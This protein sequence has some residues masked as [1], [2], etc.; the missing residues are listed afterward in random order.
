MSKGI[1]YCLDLICYV[2]SIARQLLVLTT[3]NIEGIANEE[4]VSPWQPS[5]VA[6]GPPFY[7]A[8]SQDSVECYK[9]CGV[10]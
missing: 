4:A 1:L 9:L 7:S 5:L 2:K 8:L 10:F 6:V 3:M